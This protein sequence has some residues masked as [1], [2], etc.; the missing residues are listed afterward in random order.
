MVAALGEKID[1]SQLGLKK[2]DLRQLDFEKAKEVVEREFRALARET[3]LQTITVDQRMEKAGLILDS[4][5]PSVV[6][7][8]EAWLS[9]EISR[10]KPRAT[11]FWEDRVSPR[12]ASDQMALNGGSTGRR[13]KRVAGRGRII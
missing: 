2:N 13:I 5:S 1:L 10:D 7:K 11:L 3:S 4:L 8:I 9:E 6:P 12:D